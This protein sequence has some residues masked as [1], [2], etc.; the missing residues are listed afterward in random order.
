LQAI[1]PAALLQVTDYD[2]L[3]SPAILLGRA[4]SISA[5]CNNAAPSVV[6]AQPGVTP[7]SRCVNAATRPSGVV[8][9]HCSKS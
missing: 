6:P 2:N 5:A 3:A 1:E 8:S 9:R 4:S 7:S